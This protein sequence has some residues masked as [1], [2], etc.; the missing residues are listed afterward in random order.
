M[1]GTRALL[2]LLVL[3][4]LVAGCVGSGPSSAQRR[5]GQRWLADHGT[6]W[7]KLSATERAQAQRVM[8]PAGNDLGPSDLVE[9]CRR[10][11]PPAAHLPAFPVDDVQDAMARSGSSLAGALRTSAR[12][13]L[14]LARQRAHQAVD[15]LSD[16]DRLLE[17]YR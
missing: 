14:S 12:A 4:A 17:E 1:S 3:A 11:S 16:S 5:A 9:W 8:G 7:R 13:D 2:S 6:A 15:H 10:T